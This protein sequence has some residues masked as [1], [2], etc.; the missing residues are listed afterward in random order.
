MARLKAW[1]LRAIRASPT[2]P[3]ASPF[4]RSPEALGTRSHG[5]N[6]IPPFDYDIGFF[7][8]AAICDPRHVHGRLDPPAYSG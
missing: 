2:L 1:F 7:H 8:N 6:R 4:H 3:P 5:K